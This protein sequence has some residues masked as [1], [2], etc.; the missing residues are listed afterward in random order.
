MAEADELN[1]TSENK[2][3]PDAIFLFIISDMICLPFLL[4]FRKI[5]KYAAQVKWNLT[6]NYLAICREL[7]KEKISPLI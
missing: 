6:G 7:F 3:I 4:F 5:Q 1:K 2:P